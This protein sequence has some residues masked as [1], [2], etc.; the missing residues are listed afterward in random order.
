M[1][2]E[3]RDIKGELREG[4]GYTKTIGSRKGSRCSRR[5]KELIDYDAGTGYLSRECIKELRNGNVIRTLFNLRCGN[6]EVDNKFWLQ[7]KG[8]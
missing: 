6:M 1:F 2:E 7:E 4:K 5:Y 3:E 8:L